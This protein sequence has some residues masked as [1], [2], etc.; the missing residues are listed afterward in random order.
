[1]TLYFS[2]VVLGLISAILVVLERLADQRVRAETAL[3]L[4]TAQRVFDANY[5]LRFQHLL[6]DCR[7]L[8]DS[9]RLL[10]AVDTRDPATVLD[11]ARSL[12][13]NDRWDL[14]TVTD[15]RGTI[16]ARMNAPG[17][18]GQDLSSTDYIGKALRGEE[19]AATENRSG[20]LYQMAS[21]PLRDPQLRTPIGA[22]SIGL[23]VDD[24]L[25]RTLKRL[26]RS[27]VAFL[28]DGRVLAA[29]LPEEGWQGLPRVRMDSSSP[30]GTSDPAEVRI[31]VESRPGRGSTFWFTLPKCG[32]PGP[33]RE[34]PVAEGSPG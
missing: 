14:F 16:L 5:R 34:G 19:T 1:M 24:D 28:A 26:S 11:I 22:L 3:D 32:P 30:E 13:E 12:Q 4:A 31:G 6:S 25:A 23:R 20:T 18:R 8:A 27:D 7:H 15:A 2:C 17:L 9:P 33:A 21:V 29:T 10:A